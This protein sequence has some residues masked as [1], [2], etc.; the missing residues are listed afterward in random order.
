MANRSKKRVV[1]VNVRFHNMILADDKIRTKLYAKFGRVRC[2]LYKTARSC[3]NPVTAKAIEKITG[4]PA[5]AW[6]A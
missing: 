5:S 3:P 2:Y 4:I 1:P 6:A